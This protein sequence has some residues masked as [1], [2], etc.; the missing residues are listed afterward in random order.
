MQSKKP[1]RAKPGKKRVRP[2]KR[3]SY[4]TGQNPKSEGPTSIAEEAAPICKHGK[5]Q[6]IWPE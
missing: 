2:G 3:N 1:S 5:A 4:L 6:K